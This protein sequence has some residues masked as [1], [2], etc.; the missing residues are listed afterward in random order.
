[1]TRRRTGLVVA[2]FWILGAAPFS[3][4]RAQY[5]SFEPHVSVP[6]SVAFEVEMKIEPAGIAV[7]G[8]DTAFDYDP[9][10]VRLDAVA[11]GGWLAASGLEHF[12]WVDPD[13]PAGSAVVHAA[14][15]GGGSAAD[16]VLLRLSFTA[17]DSGVSPLGF[18]AL[19]LR[20][21]VNTPLAEA[22]HSEGD[23]IVVEEA[24]A[25]AV[26]TFGGLKSLWR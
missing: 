12:L 1:M 23:L 26:L 7:Q 14:L 10:I 4:A 21:V 22:T 6:I 11:A 24:V 2:L 3:A 17:L 18:T 16:G 13:A 15:L 25:A 5:V 8:I 19:D 9:S 20:D